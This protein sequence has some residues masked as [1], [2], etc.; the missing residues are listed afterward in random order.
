M[1]RVAAI[2]GVPLPIM[3]KICESSFRCLFGHKVVVRWLGGGGGVL[4][5]PGRGIKNILVSYFTCMQSGDLNR[6]DK[7]YLSE[8]NFNLLK[9]S[10]NQEGD[11]VV[12][13]D[14]DH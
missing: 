6:A 9:G 8:L 10:L 14:Y 4:F 13:C 7:N 3:R 11:G 1:K 5:R 12:Y 2:K